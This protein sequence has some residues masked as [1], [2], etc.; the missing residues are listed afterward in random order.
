M[1]IQTPAVLLEDFTIANTL[2]VT[3]PLEFIS[4]NHMHSWQTKH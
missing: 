3:Q 2:Y 1:V 4:P